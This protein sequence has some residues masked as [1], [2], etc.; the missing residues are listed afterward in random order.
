MTSVTMTVDTTFT[1][2]TAVKAAALSAV[3]AVTAVTV[4][5]CGAGCKEGSWVPVWPRLPRLSLP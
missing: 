1:A 4:L 2:V 3:T 5:L